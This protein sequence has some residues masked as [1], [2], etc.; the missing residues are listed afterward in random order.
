M[1]LETKVDDGK[2]RQ[3]V[4]S[5]KKYLNVTSSL[6]WNESIIVAAAYSSVMFRVFLEVSS[7]HVWANN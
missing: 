4:T 2:R 7:I 6:V 1:M 3:V 5:L